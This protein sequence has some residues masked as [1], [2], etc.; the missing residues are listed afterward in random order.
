MVTRID[1]SPRAS[2]LVIA[3]ERVETAGL[4]ARDCQADIAG[5]TRDVLAQLDELLERAGAGRAGLLRIQIWL[6]DMADFEAM[7]SVYDAWVGG[8]H[9]PARACVGAQLASPDY[10]I[11]IQA[12]A[13]R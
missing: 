12:S 8:Q 10:L 7:N 6:A 11:E 4:V 1:V 3:N 2:R 9:Q 13:Q 5:Q